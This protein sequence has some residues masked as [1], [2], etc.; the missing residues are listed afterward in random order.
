MDL[1]DRKILYEL[2]F[3]AGQSY[4]QI[5]KKVGLKKETVFHRVKRLEELKIIRTYSLGINYGLIGYLRSEIYVKLNSIIT[6]KHPLLKNLMRNPKII[7]VQYQAGL[8]DLLLTVYTKDD[9]ELFE[10]LDDLYDNK[11]IENVDYSV[12]IRGV[13]QGFKLFQLDKPYLTHN[14][15]LSRRAIEISAEDV[16]LIKAFV[17]PTRLSF[18]DV[19]RKLKKPASQVI[20]RYNDLRKKGVIRAR[21]AIINKNRL[22]RILESKGVTK[23]DNKQTFIKIPKKDRSRFWNSCLSNEGCIVTREV[24]NKNYN[25]A[26]ESLG[27]N[28]REFLSSLSKSFP[29]LK[30]VNQ[31]TRLGDSIKRKL[32]PF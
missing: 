28:Y 5:G 13:W 14:Y 25:F 6:A 18:V 10:I 2:K 9:F 15:F 7:T 26:I 24:V 21:V 31:T 4:S 3:D 12:T 16:A 17:H 19:A 32:H 23:G 29:D 27:V 1:K 22:N 8:A 11:G 30:I 20:Y